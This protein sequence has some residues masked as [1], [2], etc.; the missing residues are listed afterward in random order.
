MIQAG[1]SH[2]N[3][4]NE[5]L[6]YENDGILISINGFRASPIQIVTAHIT[7][8]RGTYMRDYE[9]NEEGKIQELSFFSV[10]REDL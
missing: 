4:Y 10:D 3:L 5:L 8:D 9:W 6:E 7:K 2:K 1:F